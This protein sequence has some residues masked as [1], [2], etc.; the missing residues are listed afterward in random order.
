MTSP[1]PER[2]AIA[3]GLLAGSDVDVRWSNLGFWPEADDYTQACRALARKHGEAIGLQSGDRLLDA[4]CGAGAALSLWRNEFAV[5]D[6]IGMDCRAPQALS[7]DGLIGGWFDRPLPAALADCQFDAI[8]CVDA[9]YHAASLS[10]LLSSL[11]PALAPGG[12]LAMTLLLQPPTYASKAHWKRRLNKSALRAAAMSASLF[13]EESTLRQ[14]LLMA[15]FEDV[16][17]DDLSAEVLAGFDRWVRYRESC[18]TRRQRHSL[19]WLKIRIT[20]YWC[21]WLHRHDMGRYVLVSASY[22]QNSDSAE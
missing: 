2:F 8:V 17:C 15:G 5:T 14:Q 22:G 16:Q 20:A 11:T 19:A 9:A 21:R 18:L 3:T 13:C 6:V 12:R 1:D 4:G 7:D 10:A